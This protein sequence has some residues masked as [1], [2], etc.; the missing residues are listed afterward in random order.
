MHSGPEKDNRKLQYIRFLHLSDFH[1]PDIDFQYGVSVDGNNGYHSPQISI[2]DEI[3]KVIED[4]DFILISGDFTNNSNL[5]AFNDCLSFIDRKFSSHNIKIYSV[6]GN[7]DLERGYGGKKFDNF[8]KKAQNYYPKIEFC[9]NEVCEQKELIS[10]KSSKPRFDLLLINTCK[11]SSDQPIIPEKLK[12]CVETSIR[13]HLNFNDIDKENMEE[14]DVEEEVQYIWNMIKLEIEEST[15]IDGIYF[16]DDDYIKLKKEINLL[17]SFICLSHYN[18]VSFSGN[19]KLSSFFSDQ[20]IFRDILVN[21]KNT[22]IYLN[23]HTHTQECTVI[24]NPEDCTNKVV[25]ITSPPLF[26]IK[27]SRLNGFNVVDIVLRNNADGVYKPIGCKLKQIG[28][29]LKESIAK[30]KKIRF[31][32]NITDV[33]FSK[34]ESDVIKALKSPAFKTGEVRLK[35]LMNFLNSNRQ[36]SEIIHVDE[37]HEILMYLWWIG[38]IDEYSAMKRQNEFEAKL[39]DYVRGVLCV[40]LNH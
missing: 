35:N 23:G 5:N 40:P 6:L 32:K 38:V 19:D 31:S 18:L 27:S 34:N 8:L 13:Y 26:K 25:C 33:S 21:H 3:Y 15:L 24:E 10:S 7:H 39:I 9:Q 30:C 2:L 4:V 1:Y 36:E 16:D 12:K 14:A 17:E 11:H 29:S 22:V 28:S 20:G 37:V